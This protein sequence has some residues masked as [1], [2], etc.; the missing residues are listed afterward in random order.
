M[1]SK[2]LLVI[3]SCA[4]ASVSAHGY[5]EEITIAGESYV[6]YNPT[7][8]PWVPVQDGIAWRN[9]ATDTGYVGSNN[10]SLPHMACHL[11]SDPANQTATITAGDKVDLRWT[12]W[13]D[14][15]HGPVMDYLAY[16]GENCTTVN[17]TTLEW[18]KLAEVGQLELGPGEGT[19]GYWGSDELFKTNFTWTVTIPANIKPGN[20]VL[21]HEILALH[22]A[23]DEG[24]AQFY[25]QCINLQVTGNGTETPAGTIA[26]ELY[27]IDDPGVLYNIYNDETKP[28][29]VI[30]GPPI[31]TASA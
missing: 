17:K 5:V 16:C 20:Y 12:G 21:R 27:K 23:Y 4:A 7:I 30:P 9:W 2:S 8:A 11:F 19:P 24:Q 22:S 31:Y 14:S 10:V 3:L 13:P 25:P 28:T 6:G 18:F 29:Y 26:T 1:L 15:H